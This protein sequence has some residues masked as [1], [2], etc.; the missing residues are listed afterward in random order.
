MNRSVFRSSVAALAMALAGTL[1]SCDSQKADTPTGAPVAPAEQAAAA[2]E[3]TATPDPKIVIRD[4]LIADKAVFDQ[5]VRDID[6][7]PEKDPLW[8]SERVV[9]ELTRVKLKFQREVKPP[10]PGLEA[11]YSSAQLTRNEAFNQWVNERIEWQHPVKGFLRDVPEKR[12]AME[13]ANQ[14]LIFVLNEI[15]GKYGL[16]VTIGGT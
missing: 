10:P 6:A 11:S 15:A 1:A 5:A 12:R 13:S 3:P 8:T 14:Q 4:F 2:P 7:I 9:S 16:Q